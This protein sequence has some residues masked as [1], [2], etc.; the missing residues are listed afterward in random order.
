M[1][2]FVEHIRKLTIVLICLFQLWF[3]QTAAIS[4][5]KRWDTLCVFLLTINVPVEVSGISFNI[6]NQVLYVQIILP[7]H[8]SF[9]F[10]SQKFNFLPTFATARLIS[11]NMCTKQNSRLGTASNKIT[12]GL[13]LVCGRPTL[14]LSSDLVPQTLSCLVCVEDS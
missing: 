12:G 11:L 1:F 14:A 6:T 2:T 10:P 9:N 8:I 4:L 7:L 3:C 5:L 13:Q